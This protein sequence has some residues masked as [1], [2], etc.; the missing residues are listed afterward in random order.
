MQNPEIEEPFSRVISP[1]RDPDTLVV[2]APVSTIEDVVSPRVPSLTTAA[3]SAVTNF[4]LASR[5]APQQ[6]S[7]QVRPSLT[8]LAQPINS[9][10][11][12]ET[13]VV[14]TVSPRPSEA[15]ATQQGNKV[16]EGERRL[17]ETRYTQ[18]GQAVKN[19]YPQPQPLVQ[20]ESP[21]RVAS[22]IQSR[23]Q[24]K[25][26]LDRINKS[27]VFVTQARSL[28]QQQRDLPHTSKPLAPQRVIIPSET[29]ASLLQ[30][31]QRQQQ[32]QQQQHYQQMQN[33][34]LSPQSAPCA[35]QPDPSP[36][37]IQRH[38]VAPTPIV[39]PSLVSAKPRNP[40]NGHQ[41]AVSYST[42]SEQISIRN[43]CNQRSN[44]VN[45]NTPVCEK[46]NQPVNRSCGNSPGSP[47]LASTRAHV[48]KTSERREITAAVRIALNA[49][50]QKES[51]VTPD[52]SSRN[53]NRFDIAHGSTG[54]R[55][56]VPGG[57][58]STTVST[59][60]QF[61]P[62]IQS[63]QKSGV[64]V[65]AR[66]MH[67]D[68]KS[69][70]PSGYRIALPSPEY[71]LQQQQLQFESTSQHPKANQESQMQSFQSRSPNRLEERPSQP[72]QIITTRQTPAVQSHHQAATRSGYQPI[73]TVPEKRPPQAYRKQNQQTQTSRSHFLPNA[74]QEKHQ[75]PSLTSEATN[76]NVTLQSLHRPPIQSPGISSSDLRNERH[77]QVAQRPATE[78][79]TASSVPT[80]AKQ[81]TV[82]QGVVQKSMPKPSASIAVMGSSIVLSWNMEYDEAE[83]NVDNYELFAC[84][85]L[86]ETDGQPIKWKKI[87]IV[88]SLPLPMACTLTQFSSGSKYF[89][90]VRAVDEYERAG[91]FS[92]PCTVSLNSS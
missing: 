11:S 73:L 42:T 26:N 18:L 84:Q 71:L 92:D 27:Q 87:G 59:Y 70:L 66:K 90:S 33:R 72:T 57:A 74:T 81:V 79:P 16:P 56:E 1:S 40:N 52:Y 41:T 3:S 20:T 82:N 75:E 62:D 19:P 48:G 89:F 38:S 88:K 24:T 58:S 25:P 60:N 51:I 35:R 5:V 9:M 47:L 2:K 83:I 54:I 29:T 64:L 80:N 45:S 17:L 28:L 55:R 37:P 14:F 43:P 50:Y 78:N 15:H 63:M 30:Q 76:G 39:P 32:L 61:Q 68:K 21:A 31:L 13:T 67:L 23:S 34:Q 69:F 4:T 65:R 77:S 91:P 7:P 46:L 12:E 6:S 49:N 8:S 36:Q 86:T 10:V 44:L 53:H 22:P 85:D